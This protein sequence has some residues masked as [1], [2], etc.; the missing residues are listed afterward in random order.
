[1][2]FDDAIRVLELKF[3]KSC[4]GSFHAPWTYGENEGDTYYRFGI[5]VVNHNQVI[6]LANFYLNQ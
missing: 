4:D 6:P 1:M 5:K 2:T 3:N